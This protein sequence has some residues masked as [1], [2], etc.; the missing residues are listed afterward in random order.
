M[1]LQLPVRALPAVSLQVNC[2]G[3]SYGGD[4]IWYPNSGTK[5]I[6][7]NYQAIPAGS[8]QASER[9]SNA[10]ECFEVVA[11]ELGISASKYV[12]NSVANASMPAGCTVVTEAD[13]TAQ[14][15][16]NTA[17]SK[18][19]CANSTR[20]VGLSVTQVSHRCCDPTI[21]CCILSC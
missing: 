12:N 8:C 9:L 5:E 13:G 1:S 16:Y 21:W 6:T 10:Q 14:I 4:P 7:H 2:V 3:A 15:F 20:H 18:Q 19:P 11:A 17:D